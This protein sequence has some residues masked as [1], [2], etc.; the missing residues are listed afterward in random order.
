MWFIDRVYV[1][2]EMIYMKF[3][4]QFALKWRNMFKVVDNVMNKNCLCGYCCSGLFSILRFS[5]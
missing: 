1:L 3:Y 5:Q 4:S 2:C